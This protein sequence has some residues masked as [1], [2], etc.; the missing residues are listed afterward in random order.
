M[1]HQPNAHLLAEVG[2]ANQSVMGQ[3]E[4]TT[5]AQGNQAFHAQRI[6]ALLAE[7]AR[8]I[9]RAATV[10]ASVEAGFQAIHTAKRQAGLCV[11][12]T[13]RRHFHNE[14]HKAQ[15]EIGQL[16]G[17]KLPLG[18]VELRTFHERHEAI[19]AARIALIQ[20]KI[21][22][23]LAWL[24]GD[25]SWERAMSAEG[26]AKSELFHAEHWGWRL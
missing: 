17:V 2:A 10:A 7:M 19:T 11:A 16:L 1:C 4:Y 14:A 23:E 22:L 12:A 3:P 15:L 6:D 5:T 9:A 21:N 18:V 13:G 8:E 25:G 26:R 20:A 24:A